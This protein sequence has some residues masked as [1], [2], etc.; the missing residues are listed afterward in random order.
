MAMIRKEVQKN[1]ST[2]L[3]REKEKRAKLKNM[4]LVNE[5]GILFY[6]IR[7][8]LFVSRKT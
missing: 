1:S 7:L 3:I 5:L 4:G 8:A 2:E 6:V